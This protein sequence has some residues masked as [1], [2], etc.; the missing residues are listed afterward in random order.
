MA[1]FPRKQVIRNVLSG[2]GTSGRES[3]RNPHEREVGIPDLC[4]S[5][6]RLRRSRKFGRISTEKSASIRR[7]SP[8]PSV[9][10]A[11]PRALEKTE[12]HEKI[13]RQRVARWPERAHQAFGWDVRGLRE[14]GKSDGRVDV[15]AQD[16]FGCGDVSGDQGLNALA[17][18]VPCGTSGHMRHGRGWSPQNHLSEPPALVSHRSTRPIFASPSTTST[19]PPPDPLHLVL[20]QCQVTSQ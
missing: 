19:N 1:E 8:P 20:S 7:Y 14:V 4:P 11:R 18:K 3:G 17:E 13:I 6:S 5:R 10:N 9:G 15:I 12:N 16:R 2:L